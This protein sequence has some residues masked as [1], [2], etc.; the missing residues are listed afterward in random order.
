PVPDGLLVVRRVPSDQLRGQ[1][2]GRGEHRLLRGRVGRLPAGE[3][4]VRL[5][6]HPGVRAPVEHS[7]QATAGERQHRPDQHRYQPHP[8]SPSRWYEAWTPEDA[9]EFRRTITI[10]LRAL[11]KAAVLDALPRVRDTPEVPVRTAVD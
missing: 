4:V 8:A 11:S 9:R 5:F 6:A 2:A 3:D 1:P 10:E 7:W